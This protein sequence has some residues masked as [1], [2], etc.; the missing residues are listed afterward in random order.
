MLC[1]QL[2]Y[3]TE[4]SAHW[5]LF[6]HVGSRSNIHN[7]V[8]PPMLAFFMVDLLYIYG[9]SL[10]YIQYVDKIRKPCLYCFSNLSVSCIAPQYTL[11]AHDKLFV[12]Y[13]FYCQL[14][15]M[16]VDAKYNFLH[17]FLCGLLLHTTCLQDDVVTFL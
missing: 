8:M 13:L 3:G 16:A 14:E 4:R 17:S 10:A 12:T 11:P 1:R 9:N 6:W 5:S 2:F 15:N 7:Y